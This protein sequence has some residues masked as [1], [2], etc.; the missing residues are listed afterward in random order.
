MR[1]LTIIALMLFCHAC[2]TT[3]NTSESGWEKCERNTRLAGMT[4]LVGGIINI[5]CSGGAAIDR[6]VKSESKENP[7]EKNKDKEKE[8]AL[9]SESH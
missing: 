8:N 6:A 1:K 4:S 2:A 5:F 7:E 9:L 3:Q